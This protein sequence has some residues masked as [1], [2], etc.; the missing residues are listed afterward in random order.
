MKEVGRTLE[1]NRAKLFGCEI[2]RVGGPWNIK[3]SIINSSGVRG[4]YS[5]LGVE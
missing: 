2:V 3:E 5:V 1:R 4:K